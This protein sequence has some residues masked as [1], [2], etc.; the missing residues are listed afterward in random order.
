MPYGYNYNGYQTGYRQSNAAPTNTQVK[1]EN[2]SSSFTQKNGERQVTQYISDESGKI[3]GNKIVFTC[4]PK[5]EPADVSEPIKLLNQKECSLQLRL[6]P[7]Q[8]NTGGAK[9]VF[10]ISWP[11]CNLIATMARDCMAQ[12]YK[13]WAAESWD[14]ADRWNRS[15]E[16]ERIFGNPLPPATMMQKFPGRFSS[17]QDASGYCPTRILILRRAT[18]RP[19]GTESRLPWYI[20]IKN[21]YAKKIMVGNNGAAVMDGRSF[22]Q[23]SEAHTNV[24]DG[25][26]YN[27]FYWNE[28][29]IN[30]IKT[31]GTNPLLRGFNSLK[32]R[33]KNWANSAK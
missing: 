25:D 28:A 17:Q 5:A 18:K 9:S 31:A 20:Q 24:A 12:P 6:M 11:Q 33:A 32:E 1:Q 2:V 23:E 22:V 3:I 16:F 29:A 27:M 4:A 19:D 7:Y 14:L 21:G 15:K 30:A 8:G 26:M 13:M 10:N